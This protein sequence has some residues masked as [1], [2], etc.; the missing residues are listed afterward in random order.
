M[1]RRPSS[2]AHPDH[3]VAT[4]RNAGGEL[5]TAAVDPEERPQAALRGLAAA[6]PLPGAAKSSS[7]PGAA[8]CLAGAAQLGTQAI[9]P[10]DHGRDLFAHLATQAGR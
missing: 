2:S 10:L 5:L 9:E 1:H 7:G 6:L 8:K 3:L 4:G